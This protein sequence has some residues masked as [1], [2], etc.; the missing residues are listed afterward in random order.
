M[1]SAESP[2]SP[3]SLW[4]PEKFRKVASGPGVTGQVRQVCC[5]LLGVSGM[6]WK[7]PYT[8]LMEARKTHVRFKIEL[9]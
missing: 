2:W 8:T 5:D 1:Q 7:S 3:C 4:S 6:V 9:T